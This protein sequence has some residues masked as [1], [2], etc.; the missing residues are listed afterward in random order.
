MS[1]KT[2]GLVGTLALAILFVVGSV[3]VPAAY[4]NH[5]EGHHDPPGTFRS[6]LEA[7]SKSVTVNAG[8]DVVIQLEGDSLLI[9]FEYFIVQEGSVNLG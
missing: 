5:E 2:I 8:E 7:E 6:S 1:N 9:D 3:F 4:A